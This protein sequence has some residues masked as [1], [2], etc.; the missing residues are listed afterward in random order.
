MSRLECTTCHQHLPLDVDSCD[1]LLVHYNWCEKVRIR[2]KFFSCP[3][4]NDTVHRGS[5]KKHLGSKSKKQCT[6][7]VA[8]TLQFMSCV[9]KKYAESHRPVCIVCNEKRWPYLGHRAE[10]DPVCETCRFN[11]TSGNTTKLRDRDL[12]GCA[13]CGCQCS[14]KFVTYWASELES[15]FIGENCLGKLESPASKKAAMVATM[16]Q[17]KVKKFVETAM[18]SAHIHQKAQSVISSD[19]AMNLNK[20]NSNK[21]S[22]YFASSSAS[23]SV[24]GIH[25][26]TKNENPLSSIAVSLNGS[27]SGLQSHFF[28]S[29]RTSKSLQSGMFLMKQTAAQDHSSILNKSETEAPVIKQ[30]KL[31]HCD[32]PIPTRASS[33]GFIPITGSFKI[34]NRMKLPFASLA[35]I[36][37]NPGDGETMVP[38]SSTGI[39]KVQSI[40]Q[41]GVPYTLLLPNDAPKVVFRRCMPNIT[42]DSVESPRT[43]FRAIKPCPDIPPISVNDDASDADAVQSTESPLIISFRSKSQESV[44]SDVSL[45]QSCKI[46]SRP[47]SLFQVGMEP[48]QQKYVIKYISTLTDSGQKKNSDQL[49]E[50]NNSCIVIKTSCNTSKTDVPIL[51]P[52]WVAQVYKT[53]ENVCSEEWEGNGKLEKKRKRKPLVKTKKER[54]VIDL[55]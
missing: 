14:E 38:R 25:E 48:Q 26:Q 21:E 4:C 29:S 7:N 51:K 24:Q 9:C 39:N 46:T 28:I 32:L 34:N 54:E 40:V 8:L 33:G 50:K 18:T 35:S 15:L 52:P 3:Y 45:S 20:S 37:D 5:I 30:I 16:K 22:Q 55:D 12:A 1:Q 42:S 11:I 49:D 31:D 44:P 36:A 43:V 47:S 2:E 17:A 53:N 19:F 23:K 27:S 41:G 10:L 6:M 13:I